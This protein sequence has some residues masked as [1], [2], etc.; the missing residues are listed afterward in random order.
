MT[1]SAGRSSVEEL[2]NEELEEDPEEGIPKWKRFGEFPKE[3]CKVTDLKPNSSYKLRVSA[4]NEAGEGRP[5]TTMP[6]MTK[7]KL[8]LPKK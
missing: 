1:G 8:I 3:T 4:A 7:K 6:A 2:A 5:D